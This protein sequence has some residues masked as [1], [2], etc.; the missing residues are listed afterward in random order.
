MCPVVSEVVLNIINQRLLNRLI[1]R[2]SCQL[3]HPV[4][5]IT[6]LVLYTH[7]FL[8][9]ADDLDEVTHDVGEECY[10]TKHQ[11]NCKN[12]F[13]VTDRK[14]ISVSNS[15]ET[16]QDIVARDQQLDIFRDGLLSFSFFDHVPMIFNFL[17]NFRQTQSELGDEIIHVF[18]F[19]VMVILEDSAKEEPPASKE[20]SDDTCDDN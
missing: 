4:S 6:T 13:F 2:E 12:S 8:I 18:T 14:V 7:L 19:G 10:S 17:V 20:V 15:A 5:Q 11:N 1:V 3:D 16:C 9:V